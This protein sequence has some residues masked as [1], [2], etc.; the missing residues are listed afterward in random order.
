MKS[1]I[2]GYVSWLLLRVVSF[3]TLALAGSYLIF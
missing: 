3:G 2:L 1:F